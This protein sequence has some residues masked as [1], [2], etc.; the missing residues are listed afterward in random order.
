VAFSPDGKQL[1]S[2]SGTWSE[3]E[4]VGE[5][6]LWDVAT[7]KELLTLPARDTK[8]VWSVCFS[9]D[10]KTLV[11]ASRD[12]TI[13]L[14]EVATWQER[15]ALPLNALGAAGLSPEQLKALWD[16]L[17]DLDAAKAYRALCT[18]V[19]A[20]PQAVALAGERLRPVHAPA[21]QQTERL[22]G[23]LEGTGPS[24]ERLQALRGIEVLELIGSRD[25]RQ[26]LERLAK[27]APEAR[28]TQEAKASLERL[29][30]R[31]VGSP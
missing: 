30:L 10:G 14:W 17:A 8:A 1:A 6:K 21:P 26:V 5:V 31:P 24:G 11:T 29:A 3:P 28:L 12:H 20:A 9:P 25:A 2:T 27:G 4:I 7:G 18:L 23:R 22:L 16:D 15:L 19:Q 13:R